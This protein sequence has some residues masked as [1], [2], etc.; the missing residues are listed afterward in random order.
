MANKNTVLEKNIASAFNYKYKNFEAGALIHYTDFN[1][2]LHPTP[3]LYNQFY[4]KG[5]NHTNAGFFLNYHWNNFAFFSEVGHSIGGGTGTIMGIVGSITPALDISWLARKFDRNFISL[6]SN[7][8]AENTT[9]QNE[10]AMYWGWKYVFSKKYSFSGYVDLFRFPWLRYRNYSPS[11]GSEWLLRFNY[12]PSKSI[13]LFLQAREET[14]VRNSST[15][16]NLY[17]TQP[18]T[19]RNY[20]IN[21]DYKVASYLTFK[22]RVQFSTYTL[23]QSASNGIMVL[24]DATWSSGKFSISGRYA[25][26]D[27]DDY[28][29]RIYVYEKDVWMAFSFPAYYG[30]GVRNYLLIQYSLSKNADLWLR[31]SQV[32]FTDRDMIGSGSEAIEGNVRNDVKVQIRIR[33]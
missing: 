28:D 13:L 12:K 11:E 31:W 21:I 8:L 26:F 18:G 29:N 5:S 27:T 15:D 6:Y 3:S 23:G 2:P 30:V 24:Q 16:N 17:L 33:L 14:K 19:K 7:A 25:L 22:T 1:I 20:W 32:R 4:F 10:T 9:P